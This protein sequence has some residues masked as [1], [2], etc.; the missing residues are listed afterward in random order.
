MLACLEAGQLGP[1]AATAR[2]LRFTCALAQPL[3]HSVVLRSMG[4][5]VVKDM[6]V[7]AKQQKDERLH[8]W[9]SQQQQGRARG[10]GGVRACRTE[11]QPQPFF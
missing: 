1:R 10:A 9:A 2:W 4:G 7:T 8:R 3:L 5:L 11:R 6:L